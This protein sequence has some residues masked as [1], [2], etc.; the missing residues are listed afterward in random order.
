M[1]G[2]FDTSDEVG[3]EKVRVQEI[4]LIELIDR[5]VIRLAAASRLNVNRGACLSTDGGVVGI[6]LNAELLD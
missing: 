4:V 3:L 2:R 1:N 5:A 6:G